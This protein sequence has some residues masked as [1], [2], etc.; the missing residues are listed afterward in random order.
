MRTYDWWVTEQQWQ[1]IISD[2]EKQADRLFDD[3][4]FEEL[5][6]YKQEG[7]MKHYKDWVKEQTDSPATTIGH[8]RPELTD[9]NL[10]KLCS[11]M[12]KFV[13]E[14]EQSFRESRSSEAAPC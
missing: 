2:M 12:E 11:D 5:D 4:M 6:K 1:T 10:N 14:L 3:P 13:E 8:D 9:E 7:K